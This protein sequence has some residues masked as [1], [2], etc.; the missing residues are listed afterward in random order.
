VNRGSRLYRLVSPRALTAINIAV[1]GACIG[2]AVA[3]AGQAHWRPLGLLALLAGFTAIAELG[4][5]PFPGDMKAALSS[6]GMAL[7]MT[8]LGTA[9][10]LAIALPPVAFDSLRRRIST[11]MVAGNVAS[12][13]LFT[14]VGSLVVRAL[15]GGDPHEVAPATLLY[16]VG[17]LGILIDAISFPCVLVLRA[18]DADVSV[19]RSVRRV[20]LPLAPHT[21][22]SAAAAASAAVVYVTA[23]LGA[24]T[25][26]LAVSLVS[27]R[28]MRFIALAQTREQQLAE[29]AVAR[30]RLLG[31][32][33]T[34]EE[35]E[36]VRLA[37]EIHDDAL[38][39]LAVA[40]L[41]LDSGRPGGAERA[42]RSLLAAD[43]ALRATLARVM[44]AAEMRVG[45]LSA[46]LEA[47]AADLC[48]PAGLAWTVH[49]DPALDGED[50]TLV[51]S[52]AREL[53]TN[54]VKHAHASRVEV[55][56]RRTAVGLSL[57]VRDD[58]R[59]FDP[60]AAPARGHVGL[61]LV[62]NRARAAD[63]RLEIRSAPGEGTAVQ[64][65]L[66]RGSRPSGPG[67]SE[68]HGDRGA[69]RPAAH[70]A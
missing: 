27:G 13:A 20:I 16:A 44:P 37:G 4:N 6:L 45:G 31:E 19:R 34:A 47:M 10:A 57:E 48:E 55:S 70:D 30:A 54:A 64:V 43:A 11:P 60:D 39:E 61:T 68:N 15:L 49:V 65:A 69:R 23:G 56:A 35:R 28:L 63:G 32:A 12:Y 50:P 8:F 7:A 14:V 59:G 36:R 62:E 66:G 5:I 33:L 24:L 41:E 40:R 58:G 17:L 53:V 18:L 22:V 1:L 42:R 29:L 3:T 46:V 21:L 2:V 25:V 52:I 38:Q 51:A 9:P 26:L 67:E